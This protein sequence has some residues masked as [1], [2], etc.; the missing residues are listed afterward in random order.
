MTAPKVTES[1]LS[2]VRLRLAR[3][4]EMRIKGKASLTLTAREVRTV[5]A[6][7]AVT[8]AMPVRGRPKEPGKPFMDSD[9]VD[10]Y[11]NIMAGAPRQPPPRGWKSAAIVDVAEI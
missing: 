6:L 4:L 8:I 2:G 10:V 9:M 7:L 1:L 11:R 3:D 5:A